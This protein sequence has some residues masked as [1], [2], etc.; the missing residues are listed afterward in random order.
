MKGG[1]WKQVPV[2]PEHHQVVAGSRA[3]S[4]LTH[5]GVEAIY[6][7]MVA[8]ARTDAAICERCHIDLAGPYDC[9]VE[10]FPCLSSELFGEGASPAAAPAPAAQPVLHSNSRQQ[11][12]SDA[13]HPVRHG[14]GTAGGHGDHFERLGPSGT[15]SSSADIAAA[16]MGD[17]GHV[18]GG[19]L[20][21][22]AGSASSAEPVAPTDAEAVRRAAL[23]EAAQEADQYD[24]G[25]GDDTP[26]GPI[27]AAQVEMAQ[28]IAAAIRARKGEPPAKAGC[29]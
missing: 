9:G 1:K 10:G 26:M 19:G 24:Q 22:D 16:G 4:F 11:E 12:P 29:E 7:A 18:V 14:P 23:E 5:E 27:M 17:E 25:P 3:C 21:A 20:R 28:R 13:Q 2:D 6:C 8:A 15:S